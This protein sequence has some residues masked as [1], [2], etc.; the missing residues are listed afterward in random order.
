M[1]FTFF[2]VFG[3]IKIHGKI[4]DKKD[5][6]II[7]A[8]V[9]LKNTYDGSTSSVD[10]IY[11]FST[12]EKDSA[13]LVVE[14]IS[15]EPYQQKIVLTGKDLEINIKAEELVT[16]LDAVTISAGMYE[17]GDEKKSVILTS[18]DIVSTAGSGA[19]IV[20]AMATL[21]GAN[22]VGGSTGLYVRGGE[23]REAQTFIDGMRVAHPFYSSVPDFSSRGRFSPFLFQG[24]YFSTGGYS[25]EYGQGLSSALVL[26]T[27]GL[28]EENYTSISLMTLGIGAAHNHAWKNTSLGLAANYSNLNPYSRIVKQDVDWTNAATGYDAS[29][30]FRKKTSKTGLLK[31]YAQ[32]DDGE[33]GY[34]MID[35]NRYPE[36][37]NFTTRGNNFY[38]NVFY[39]EQLSEKLNFTGGYSYTRNDDDIKVGDY[40]INLIDHTSVIKAK[41]N[42]MFAQ[43]SSIKFGGEAQLM[44]ERDTVERTQKYYATF[45]ESDLYLTKQFIFRI[46]LRGEYSDLVD[47]YNVAPRV[48]LAYKT[49]GM[50]QFSL[51]Y[52]KFYQEPEQEYVYHTGLNE[53]EEATHYILNYQM[54]GD[55][56]SLRIE[57]YY[58]EY[59]KLILFG[60]EYSV[61]GYGYAKGLDVFWRD[62]K[63]IP[64]ADYWISYSYLDTKRKYLYYPE[65]VMPDYACTHSLSLVYKHFVEVL[66]SNIS[67]SY[68]Y[69]SGR[70]YYNPNNA[71]FMGDRTSGQGNLN[72]SWSWIRQVKNNFYIVSVAVSNLLGAENIYGYHYTPDGLNR[73]EIK[74]SAKRFFFLGLFIS[75]GRDNTEDI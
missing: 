61:E 67:V 68:L 34:N 42:Y 26:N 18:M 65:E 14:H 25:A 41:L 1:I 54:L 55:M 74:E 62:K 29:V 9:Y 10:G 57:A 24:T 11:T 66:A 35:L 37:V 13:I 40:Q 19:D 51:A 45:A 6:P 28:E 27:I 72:L 63:S 53:Y 20:S 38:S 47:R 43:L 7:G 58:K 23:G 59:D 70:P 46:G 60:P 64:N 17:A 69:N 2:P 56:R 3:Q 44:N 30:I 8:N 22:I 4:T 50:G 71:I 36:T 39:K 52:G 16:L 5:N 48:S 75:L 32:F 33:I 15:Y 73:I 31:I 49:T 21:P 12:K